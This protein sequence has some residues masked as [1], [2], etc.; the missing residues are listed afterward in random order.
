VFSVFTV[1][2]LGVADLLASPLYQLHTCFTA[3]QMRALLAQFRTA[4]IKARLQ[5]PEA[6]AGEQEQLLAAHS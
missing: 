4:Y 6:Q 5:P 2:S 3:E 1:S